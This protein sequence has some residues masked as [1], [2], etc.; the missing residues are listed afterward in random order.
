M[1]Q[2]FTAKV[3]DIIKLIPEG[4]VMTYGQIAAL[5]GSP[6][7]ARQVVR[8]LHSMSSKYQLPWHRVINSLGEISIKDDELSALQKAFLEGEGIEVKEDNRIDLETYQF[9]PERI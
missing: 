4:K 3:I 7:G 6:R 9:H 1:L 2:P 8:I 5:A